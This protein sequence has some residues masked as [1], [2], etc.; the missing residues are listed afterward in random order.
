[1]SIEH[2]RRV[3]ELLD[4]ALEVP[5]GERT[6]Y[7][8]AHCEDE[9]T[10]R[11][12][13]AMLS[14]EP[15]S[16]VLGVPAFDV[17]AADA[18]IGRRVGSYEIVRLIDRGGMGSVYLAEREDFDQQ[19]ALKLLRRGLD[20]DDT[21]VRRFHNERQILARL[22]HPNI[23]KLLDGGTTEDRLPY[24]V[25]ELV[26]GVPIDRYCRQ[27]ELSIRE[28]LRLFRKV[29]AAV[30]F[31]HQSLVVHR[32][33]K[34]SNVLITADGEPKLLDFGIAKLLD[35]DLA[36]RTLDTAPGHGAMT[37]RYASP[38]QIRLEPVTTAS[39]VYSLGVLLYELLTGRTP[40]RL[41]SDRSD[42]VARAVC[43]QEPDKPSTAVRRQAGESSGETLHDPR[44]LR[45]LLAGDLDSIVLKAL[46]K[47]PEMRYG[48]VEQFSE[49]I[50]RYLSGLPVDAR[51][52]TGLYRFGKFVRRNRLQ[53]AVI[54][55]FLIMAI[56]FG[57]V[58]LK[59]QREAGES[60]KA[61]KQAEVQSELAA[62]ISE[63]LQEILRVANP[64]ESPGPRLTPLDLAHRA[65]DRIASKL[66]DYPETRIELSGILGALFRDLGDLGEAKEQMEISLELARSHYG[67][68]HPEVAKRLG[69]LSVVFSDLG[70]H[71]EAESLLRQAL[72]IRVK[73]GQRGQ[74]LFRP[75]SNLAT[76]LFLQEK[77]QESEKLQLEL[78]RDREKLYG[79]NDEDVATS[80]RNLGAL[81][82]A[83]DEVDKAE[84][85]L[86]RALRIRQE[87][88]EPNVLEVAATQDLLGRT[89]AALGKVAESE[90]LYR[91]ALETRKARL[92]EHHP[93]VARTQTN[94]GALLIGTDPI[95]AEELLQEAMDS[96][97]D[98]P[99]GRELAE[100]ESAYGELLAVGGKFGEAKPLLLSSYER[101]LILQGPHS[102]STRTA[103]QR[104]IDLYEKQG[105][106]QEL[107]DFLAEHPANDPVRLREANP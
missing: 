68:N 12:V 6:A 105:R 73:L 11:E 104:I 86:S 29:C 15:H 44:K 95:A 52:G 47:R 10:R 64:S 92:G 5:S 42:E 101:L 39:D 28:R 51:D 43:E 88:P 33:L 94:L 24:F 22:D 9:A 8:E 84:M 93:A 61:Q 74:E 79:D 81:Y 50:H 1:M 49:D 71:S 69:N 83:I 96:M 13:E 48:S 34:P 56:G 54:S 103:H 97:R 90:N 102:I 45:Q 77:F 57:V 41:A 21:L 37:P 2:K 26:D 4:E 14:T 27:Q 99:E 3:L 17:H 63:L 106:S 78:L 31:A 55:A 66:D 53:L 35:D 75:R 38:E 23:A 60:A 98:R 25:M 59:L 67:E 7:L 58:S 82:F 30:Q 80:L 65:K 87:S 19:V 76:S 36:A 62:R 72:N 18:A 100:A 85:Y 40:Y 20:L 89:K 46:R 70:R 32:D 107:A 91:K 16:E